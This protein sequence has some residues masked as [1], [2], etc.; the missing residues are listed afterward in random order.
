MFHISFSINWGQQSLRFLEEKHKKGHF[1]KRGGPNYDE[2]MV[3]LKA[4]LNK[5]FDSTHKENF[6]KTRETITPIVDT[7]KLWV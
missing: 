5:V 1:Q 2:T 6:N 7:R 4:S 3:R